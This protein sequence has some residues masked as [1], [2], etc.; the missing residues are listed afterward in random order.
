MCA[1]SWLPGFS[2]SLVYLILAFLTDK[3]HLYATGKISKVN[4]FITG[5][6]FHLDDTELIHKFDELCSKIV[7]FKL[8]KFTSG[9]RIRRK[10]SVWMKHG[11]LHLQTSYFDFPQDLTICVNV[12]SNPGDT[13]LAHDSSSSSTRTSSTL[14]R[15]VNGRL[16]LLSLRIFASSYIAPTVFN[17]LQ[18]LYILRKYGSCGG[19]RRLGLSFQFTRSLGNLVVDKNQLLIQVVA[20]LILLI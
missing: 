11:I 15:T 2:S 19:C 20:L 13:E 9:T 16:E 3:F 8:I 14:S 17:R 5:S 12:K 6:Q 7:K 1:P 18:S 4:T 10:S